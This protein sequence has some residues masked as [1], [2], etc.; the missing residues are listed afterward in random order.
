[1]EN[2][3]MFV[4]ALQAAFVAGDPERYG[5][6]S[7]NPVRYEVSEVSRSEWLMRSMNL[8]TGVDFDPVLITGCS[9]SAIAEEFIKHFL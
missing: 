5:H 4:Q 7:S 9:C 1:M 6:L 3:K 8:A 2:K